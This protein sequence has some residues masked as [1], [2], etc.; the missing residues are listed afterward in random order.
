MKTNRGFSIG[1]KPCEILLL[2][3]ENR[4]N[5]EIGDCLVVADS[6][7]ASPCPHSSLPETGYQPVALCKPLF[8]PIP[9]SANACG[10]CTITIA[11][12]KRYAIHSTCI[13]AQQ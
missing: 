5:A 13:A 2:K 3:P 12:F 10:I 1:R 11:D 4:G 9:D 8:L 7:M 6:T